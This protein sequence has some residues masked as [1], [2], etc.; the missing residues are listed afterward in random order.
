[1]NF[2]VQFNSPHKSYRTFA[3]TSNQ[4]S[5]KIVE[6]TWWNREIWPFLCRGNKF[7]EPL[8]SNDHIF[9][10][11]SSDFQ[12]SSHIK[13]TQQF[14]RLMLLVMGRNVWCK[15]LRW[16]QITYVPNFV[17]IGWGI[18]KLFGA[19]T[20]AHTHTQEDDLI[21]LLLFYF[22]DKENRL[23]F[24]CPN[25][26]VA[27]SLVALYHMFDIPDHDVACSTKWHLRIICPPRRLVLS[28]RQ[29]ASQPRR[30]FATF[31]QSAEC[32]HWTCV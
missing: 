14:E 29:S 9:C 26:A 23:K 18:Q 5:S 4:V 27:N 1:V 16:A 30:T 19:H 15:R 7:T 24:N 12:A 25:V 17:K 11:H 31:S 3:A 21:R 10:L 32:S 6:N 28:G 22:F 8:P 20:R 13:A 2:H